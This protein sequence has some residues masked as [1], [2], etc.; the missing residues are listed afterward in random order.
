[1]EYNRDARDEDSQDSYQ[2]S[3]QTII[4]NFNN[5]KEIKHA[6]DDGDPDLD[7]SARACRRLLCTCP[8]LPI[9]SLGHH[10]FLWILEIDCI[11]EINDRRP[12]ELSYHCLGSKWKITITNKVIRMNSYLYC[13]KFWNHTILH[14]ILD[15]IVLSIV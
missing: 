8:L 14:T 13:L 1:M 2:H 7:M 6:S 5:E 11:F 9:T 4:L 15:C 10:E 3:L 12:N